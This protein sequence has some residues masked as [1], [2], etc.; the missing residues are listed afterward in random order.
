MAEVAH[1]GVA[2]ARDRAPEGC[3]EI[4]ADLGG[5]ILPDPK[6][7]RDAARGAALNSLGAGRAAH[8]GGDP[9][10]DLVASRAAPDDR[11]DRPRRGQ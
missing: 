8:R 3:F 1:S 10:R 11:E 2:G 6:R 7:G 5:G 9:G 4:G